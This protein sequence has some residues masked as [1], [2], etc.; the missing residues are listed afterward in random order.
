MFVNA[1]VFNGSYFLICVAV[2]VLLVEKRNR[3][4]L[5]IEVH[6]PIKTESESVHARS[7]S[8]QS[9]HFRFIVRARARE[10]TAESI[11]AIHFS[12]ARAAPRGTDRGLV[13]GRKGRLCGRRAY[14][15]SDVPYRY[16]NVK[17]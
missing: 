1:E 17:S 4:T 3:N 15:S 6:T 5:Y 11:F 2:Q 7:D 9:P 13:K 12:T 10:S 8:K 16:L 14:I